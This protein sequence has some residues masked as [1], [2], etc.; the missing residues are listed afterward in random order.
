MGYDAMGPGLAGATKEMVMS[1]STPRL[2][3]AEFEQAKAIFKAAAAAAIA[4]RGTQVDFDTMAESA[5]KAAAAFGAAVKRG[6]PLG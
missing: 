6:R 5:F 3:P 4:Q 1:E 2:S